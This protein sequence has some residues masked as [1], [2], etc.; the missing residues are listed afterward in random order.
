VLLTGRRAL[1]VLVPLAPVVALVYRSWLAPATKRQ[2]RRIVR[3]AIWGGGA[4]AVLAVVVIASLGGLAPAGFI[5]M[6]ATGFQFDTDPVAML[7]R[8]Q[9]RALV[10]GWLDAPL[11]GS[12]HGVP[13]SVIRSVETPWSYELSYVAL[14]FHVG[15]LGA[16]AYAAGFVWIG[17]TAHRIARAGWTEAP[18]LV[19]TLVGT[20]MF[21]AAN[22]TN[23]YLEK[24]DYIWVI[25]LPIAF[26]NCWLVERA[27]ARG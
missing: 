23:P 6:V 25:F 9:F 27:G 12:G 18:G 13:A 16:M 24:Y 1:L 2:S 14:L 8:D 15:V 19:A 7:R 22:A 4:L 10:S 20:T 21:L 26:V 11:L 5:D 3:H 17:V